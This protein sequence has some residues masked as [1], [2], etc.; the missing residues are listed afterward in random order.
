MPRLLEVRPIAAAMD[1]VR[2]W[3]A[4]FIGVQG[5][6]R[7]MAIGAQ[8]YTALF[9]LLIVYASVLPQDRDFADAVIQR[10]EL[11]GAAASS[12]ERA[13]APSGDVRSS[14]TVIG[15]LLLLISALAFTRGL[16]RLYE[17]VF[18][19]PTLGMRNTKWGLLWLALVCLVVVLRPPLLGGLE[20]GAELVASLAVGCAVWTATPYLLLGRRVRA[21]RLAPVA[22]LSSIG[23]VGVAI[24][25]AI[26]MPRTFATSAR[27]FGIIGV[28]F[29]LLTWLVA[30]G[31]VL[32]VA[33]AGGATIADRLERRRPAA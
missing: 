20:A 19:L 8:A 32:T 12:V 1:F 21:V 17:G 22:V 24:W 30:I 6:D 25:S 27:E 7:A 10:F 3:I 29:A 28:G 16:Q 11:S 4:R 33:A 31:C 9:P 18:G 5:I 13:F 15:V 2:D 23:M 14:I 26:W